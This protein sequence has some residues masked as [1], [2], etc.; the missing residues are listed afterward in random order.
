[1][2]T[3]KQLREVRVSKV[4]TLE[5]LQNKESLNDEE[6]TSFDSIMSEIK[7]LDLDITRAEEAEKIMSAAAGKSAVKG[8]SSS[9]KKELKNY[10]FMKAIREGATGNLTG[11][12]AEMHQEANLEKKASGIYNESSVSIPSF[13]ADKRALD[14]ATDG[15]DLV[16]VD[17]ASA[18][19]PVLRPNP[20]VGSLGA[21]IITGLVGD[22]DLPRQSSA[23]AATWEGENDAN[24]ESTPGFN[25]LSLTPKRLGAYTEISKQLLAQRSPSVDALVR[26]DLEIAIANALDV[27]AINGAGSGGVPEGILNVT[28]IGNVIGGTNGAVPTFANMVALETAINSANADGDSMAYLTTPGIKGFLKTKVKEA[29]QASY[30]YEGN[31]INGYNA[32]TSTNVPSTL[33]K[34]TSSGNCHAIVFGNWRELILAQ[35][36]GVDIVVDPYSLSKN[37]KIQLVI[38]AWYD[39]AVRHAASFSAMKDAKLA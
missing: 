3:V 24:A 12:E 9:T 23:T 38:N 37:A 7:N 25:K 1:M 2:E 26:S 11:L 4:S 17:N 22:L 35:W 27:A 21:T 18:I 13:L 29:G 5:T 30:V 32:F 34:G 20:I 8:L 14:V 6:K 28:G 31:Q 33:T 19:I 36:A 10:S 15:T 16:A 39:V